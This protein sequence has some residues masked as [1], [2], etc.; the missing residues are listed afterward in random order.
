[1]NSDW[2]QALQATGAHIDTGLVTDFGDAEGELRAAQSG[3]VLADASH[4]A[5]LD[6]T[7]ADAKTF[8]HGQLTCDVNSLAI[9]AGTLGGYCSPVGRLLASFILLRMADGYRMVLAQDIAEQTRKRLSQYVLRAKVGV[10]D[11]SQELAS[12]GVAGPA[13]SS[14]LAAL[15]GEIPS[16][17]YALLSSA[18]GVG[19]IRLSEQRILVVGASERARTL[20]AELSVA[21]RPVGS[22]CWQWL[23]IA[24]GLPWISERTREA[25][26]PQMAN[27][28][29]LGGISFQKGCY[30]GQEVVARTRYRGQLKRRM[31]LAHLAAETHAGDALYCD[32]LAGQAGGTVVNAAPAPSGGWD[33]LAVVPLASRDNSKVHLSAPDGPTLE[34]HDLPYR[35]DAEL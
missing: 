2:L 18:D 27:L 6:F 9:G 31:F 10:A 28:D 4:L 11:R 22:P 30:P 32:D 25:F 7:G 35:V 20:Q 24:H 21:L 17:P 12:F 13:A 33:A 16:R 26:V 15:L 29:L 1:M 23:D 19:A 14:A 34:F 8:L 3:S 5:V